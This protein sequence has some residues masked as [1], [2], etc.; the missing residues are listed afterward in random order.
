MN[1]KISNID[2]RII[3]MQNQI[4]KRVEQLR[5]QQQAQ[6]QKFDLEKVHQTFHP[7]LYKSDSEIKVAK[8]VIK[9][10]ENATS[11]K[12]IN[13]FETNSNEGN[14]SD[15]STSSEIMELES[16]GASLDLTFTMDELS[17][18]SMF[19]KMV[20]WR[21]LEQDN[22]R[23]EEVLIK[24]GEKLEEGIVECDNSLKTGENTLDM[25]KELGYLA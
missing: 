9:K 12:K 10:Y 19:Q 7:I 25:Y 21:K 3:V 22:I 20:F 13:D 18:M 2:Q 8:A 5:K 23:I 16:I 15:E 4:Q 14:M 17:K 24:L 1:T 11:N 6:G